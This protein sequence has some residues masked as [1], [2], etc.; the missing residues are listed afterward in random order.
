MRLFLFALF[1]LLLTAPI[2]AQN[3]R[4][5][6]DP[7]LPAEIQ[8]T[9][10]ELSERAITQYQRTFGFDFPHG[11]EIVVSASADF[12][13]RDYTQ[14]LGGSLASKRRAFQEWIYAEAT[15]S[16]V[17]VNTSHQA[18]H[19][20]SSPGVNFHREAML[21][22]ELFH[23]LQY[24]L[25]GSVG[26]NCCPESATPRVGPVW[27]LEGGANYAQQ[28]ISGQLS[29][30]LSWARQNAAAPSSQLLRSIEG[31]RGINQARMGYDSGAIAID[32]LVG[33]AGVERL[34]AFYSAIG[35]TQDWRAAFSETFGMT[36]D[37]FYES[38]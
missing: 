2:S 25:S 8:Q 17:Y 14:H 4:I 6:L 30:Y 37:Q 3:I 23:V 1:S 20:P 29:G 21:L 33:R 10:Q 24:Q 26:R 16:R 18:F 5:T 13:A 32:L 27:M 12:L 7:E 11:L 28:H 15:F 22:H 9:M 31:R 19:T 35:A 38:L 34:V 36:I